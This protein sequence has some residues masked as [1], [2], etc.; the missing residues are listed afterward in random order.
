M[1]LAGNA[2][3]WQRSGSRVSAG[4][5][6]SV[7][8]NGRIQW[9]PHDPAL[10][11][12]PRF[13]LWARVAPGGRI[14]NLRHDTDTFTADCD[15]EVELGIYMGLW[16]DAYGTLA[17][18]P[19]LYR[20]LQGHLDA[21]LITWHG[22]PAAA[23]ADLVN[24]APQTQF[25]REEAARLAAAADPPAGWHYLLETGHSAIFASATGPD[26]VP[27]IRLDG[28]DDQGILCR[29]VDCA[30]TPATRLAWRWR[31]DEHPSRMPEDTVRTHDYVSI[32]TEFDN[33]R[34][35]TW[36]WSAALAPELHFHC[37]IKAWSA[38]ETHLVSRPTNSRPKTDENR[39]HAALR[40]L[41]RCSTWLWFAPCLAP[42]SQVFLPFMV[43]RQCGSGAQRLCQACPQIN[44]SGH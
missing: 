6:Y 14:V 15:G 3:P 1:R 4:Q 33:G 26:G 37:P 25:L 29:S 36:I 23:L 13:H 17:T 44:G 24:A 40:I 41:A 21:L 10:H 16:R 38:R 12:G 5:A 27:S 35:L 22:E 43:C 30:L 2:P 18:S 11:A 39:R 20:R 19:E 28:R 7:F 34:D 8:A 32:A 9:S 42:I 31:V